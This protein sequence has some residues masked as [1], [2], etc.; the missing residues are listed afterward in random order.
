[1]LQNSSASGTQ[2]K[3]F[4]EDSNKDESF[5]KE[6]ANIQFESSFDIEEWIISNRQGQ[7]AKLYLSHCQLML[8]SADQIIERFAYKDISTVKL[9]SVTSSHEG[10]WVA[11]ISECLALKF[12]GAKEDY[13]LFQKSMRAHLIGKRKNKANGN[14]IL[15]LD[16]PGTKA[17]W[18]QFLQNALLAPEEVALEDAPVPVILTSSTNPSDNG[19]D[20]DAPMQSTPGTEQREVNRR[21]K[22][23]PA[24]TPQPSTRRTRSS[25]VPPPEPTVDPDQIILI[26]PPSGTGA[27][28][29][30]NGVLKRLAPGEFLNDTLIE[31]GLKL[32][33]HNL[34]ERDPALA[35][36]VHVFSSFFYKKLKGKSP[37]DGYQSVRKWTAK[38][39][40][41]EKDYIIV[42]INENVHWYLA[43]ICH[44]SLTLR[45]PLPPKVPVRA[46]PRRGRKSAPD[47]S[48]GARHSVEVNPE[49]ESKPGHTPLPVPQEAEATNFYRPLSKPTPDLGT[50]EHDV[51]L[52]TEST[53]QVSLEDID[54]TSVKV[55]GQ[56]DSSSELGYPEPSP[57][58]AP[59]Q[60]SRASTPLIDL[61]EPMDDSTETPHIFTLDSMGS[62]HPQA[63]KIL[64]QYLA[65]EAKDKK[66]V[67]EIRNATRR[68][69]QVPSQPNFCD[70]GIYLLH[71]VRV[72]LKDPE[73]TY[74]RM[75]EGKQSNQAMKTSWQADTVPGLREE[76]VTTVL[77]LSEDWKNTVARGTKRASDAT[78]GDRGQLSDHEVEGLL[79]A[80]SERT[81]EVPASEEDEPILVDLK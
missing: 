54:I 46:S 27:L 81:A 79:E 2:S 64:Q 3:Y 53:Q 68:K 73:M 17:V 38:F 25:F 33:L 40:F 70:C 51:E 52:V 66:N 28:N 67:V 23:R 8:R 44:P 26:Y 59:K 48:F 10:P 21:P 63:H 74:L 6:T 55:D 19:S 22:P 4:A 34:R 29:I 62:N 50:L 24:I 71:F 7:G 65:E 43:I 9:S 20:S 36:K 58:D 80:T 42:P 47:L 49:P 13:T 39:D 37:Q 18:D 16:S 72:F 30:T 14:Q 75:R 5:A 15:R 1:V 61:E 11:V 31:F 56:G 45:K 60:T 69:V 12:A 78:D 76:L 32:W 35:D 41:F 77:S 57:E